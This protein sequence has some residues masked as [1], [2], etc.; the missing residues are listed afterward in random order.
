MKKGFF[1]SVILGCAATLC[2][3]FVAS[4][5]IE[6][7]CSGFVPENDLKIPVGHSHRWN[8]R[9]PR[10]GL[11]EAQF[12]GVIDRFERIFQPVFSKAGGNLVVLRKWTDSTVNAYA[13]R[14]GST[15][16]VAM[17]GGLAR[18]P[19]VTPD[20]FA[21]VICHEGS[22]HIG[23]A[24]KGRGFFGNNWASNEGQADYGATTKC[25]RTYFAQD[26]NEEIIKNSNV[27]PLAQKQCLSQFTQR[28]DQLLCMRISLAGNSVALLFMDLEKSPSPPL[29]N[30]PDLSQTS[31]MV[32]SH[33]PAQC[34]L[35]TYFAGATCHVD[36]SIP[37]SDTDYREGA[38]IQ[39][40]DAVGFRPRCWFK[41]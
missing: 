6:H 20:G 7:L 19:A 36:V 13:N 27:D 31:Q 33:P 3:G 23:G 37:V 17:F 8:F 30:T 39:P 41:P 15:W 12:N 24:P 40:I 38:C 11:T 10:S 22:H 25:L 18:H 26:D 1:R 21:L 34:R 16:N 14:M 2:L 4:N 32:D 29:F 5:H 35:D 28:A 9:G